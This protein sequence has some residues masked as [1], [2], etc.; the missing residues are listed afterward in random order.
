MQYPLLGYGRHDTA[1]AAERPMDAGVAAVL[2]R[3]YVTGWAR[4]HARSD[5]APPG[6][7]Q[8]CP[9]ARTT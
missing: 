7:T 2:A 4:L 1:N 9:A 5:A 8:A 3:P 6:P